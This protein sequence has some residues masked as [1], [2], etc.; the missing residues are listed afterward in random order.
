[1]L[2]WL[3]AVCASFFMSC[4]PV[5]V[6]LAMCVMICGILR[7]YNPPPPRPAC[8]SVPSVPRVCV[9]VS[10]PSPGV[11]CV[12]R[13][14]IICAPLVGCL[15]RAACRSTTTTTTPFPSSCSAATFGAPAVRVSPGGQGLP[16]W[17]VRLCALHCGWRVRVCVRAEQQLSPTSPKVEQERCVP[18]RLVVAARVCGRGRRGWSCESSECGGQQQQHQIPPR[19]LV[20]RVVALQQ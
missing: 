1:M 2:R 14:H 12:C 19:V 11:A 20:M 15:I 5:C 7:V 18:A 6:L 3:R 10:L 4:T 16:R 9:R 13:V 17:L 8:V